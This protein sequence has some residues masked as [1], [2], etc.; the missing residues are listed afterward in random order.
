M[1]R[2]STHFLGEPGKNTDVVWVRINGSVAVPTQCID[3][4]NMQYHPECR[5][6]G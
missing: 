6:P 1:A 5:G 2:I 4:G 3:Q